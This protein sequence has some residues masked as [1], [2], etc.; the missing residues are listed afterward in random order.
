MAYTWSSVSL[1]T[2][3]S[4]TRYEPTMRLFSTDSCGKTCRPSGTS[5]MP[6]ATIRSGERPTIDCPSKRMPPVVGTR[7]PETVFKVV[8]LPAPFPPI[9]VTISALLIVSDTSRNVAT[10]PYLT[11]SRSISSIGNDPLLEA[12]AAEIGFDHVLVGAYLGGRAFGEFLSVIED[13]DARAG[14]HDHVHVVFN[15]HYGYTLRIDPPDQR[16]E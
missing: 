7:R 9:K 13:R 5:A 4:R 10:S 6:D 11:A 8:V 3:G 16:D 12:G 2:A 15:E 14:G 1:T